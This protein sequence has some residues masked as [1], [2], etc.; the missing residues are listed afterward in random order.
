[1]TKRLLSGIAYVL[2]IAILFSLTGCTYEY[3]LLVRVFDDTGDS[4]IT[5]VRV[6]VVKKAIDESELSALISEPVN[7]AGELEVV[8]CCSPDPQVWVYAFIDSSA[9]LHWDESEKIRSAQ[10]P[11]QLSDDATLDIQ[12]E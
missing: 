10:N 4:A 3:K 7:S 5:N 12:F 2:A 1:M 11:V 6:I 8:L 9:S